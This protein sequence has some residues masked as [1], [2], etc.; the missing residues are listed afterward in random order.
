MQWK[1]AVWKHEFLTS[2]LKQQVN[3]QQCEVRFDSQ[4]CKRILFECTVCKTVKVKG[5]H[6]PYFTVI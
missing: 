6:T 4:P 2:V 1:P 3:K 5:L